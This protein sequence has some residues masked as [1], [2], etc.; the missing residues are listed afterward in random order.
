MRARNETRLT[1]VASIAVGHLSVAQHLHSRIYILLANTLSVRG[2]EAGPSIMQSNVYPGLLRRDYE[3]VLTS[4]MNSGPSITILVT[5]PR[6]LRML[7]DGSQEPAQGTI[8]G[9]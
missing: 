5:D 3:R 6:A 7:Q 1:E 9:L 4:T 2:D 8:Q